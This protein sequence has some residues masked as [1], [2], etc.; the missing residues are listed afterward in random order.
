MLSALPILFHQNHDSATEASQVFL[1]NEQKELRTLRIKIPRQRNSL[2]DI[3]CD[4]SRIFNVQFVSV[5]GKGKD[6]KERHIL[7]ALKICAEKEQTRHR[8][9][10]TEWNIFTSV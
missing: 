2:A 8:K 9:G 5:S 4:Y 10:K 7:F 1:N 6:Y 3:L